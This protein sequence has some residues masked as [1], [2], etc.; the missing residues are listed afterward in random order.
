MKNSILFTLLLV[1]GIYQQGFSQN[2]SLFAFGTPDS[3]YSEVLGEQ[4][5][6]WIHLPEGFSAERGVTYPVLYVLDGGVLLNAVATTMAYQ[7][8]AYVPEMIV[9]GISN[10]ENRTRDLTTSSIEN[11]HGR[12]VEESGGAANFS[13]FIAEELIPYIDKTYPTTPYRTLIGH[14]YG[15]LFTINM[16]MNHPGHFRNYISIDPS[17]DWDN[18]KLLKQIKAEIKNKDF[19]G[20]SLYLTM[21]NDIIRYSDDLDLETVTQDTTEFSLAMRSHLEFVRFLDSGNASNLNFAWKHHAN[22][23]HGTVPLISIFDGLRFLFDWY[24]IISPSKFNNPDTP[25]EVLIPM[26]EQRTAI[27]SEKFGY[28][29]FAFDEELMD[30]LG[31]MYLDMQ[32]Y[33]KSLA[34]L[35]L[36]QKYHP[37]SASVY[38]SLANYYLTKGEDMNLALKYALKAFERNDS[39]DYKILLDKI[40]SKL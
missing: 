8:P 3:L 28:P 30:M 17:L 27:L 23:I 26:V 7:T 19:S 11:R 34:F 13:R 12:Q 36:N 5:D 32:Q 25:I 16:M 38:F 22:E 18:Q 9:V 31:A 20:Q 4:R 21:A 10:R 37:E 14:S 40:K 24:P 39:E 2:S 35:E 15:G 6:I 33:K 1:T 29:V